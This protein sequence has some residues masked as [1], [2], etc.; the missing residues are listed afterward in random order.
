MADVARHVTLRLSNPRILSAAARYDVASVIH[1]VRCM[2]CRVT[3]T[4]AEPSFLEW[5]SM[6][7]RLN[8]IL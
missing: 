8:G 4:Q 5:H 6:T 7:R 1:T 2:S 3:H